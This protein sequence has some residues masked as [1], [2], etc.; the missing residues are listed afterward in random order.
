MDLRI[1]NVVVLGGGT[2]G[3]MSAAYL[4]KHLQALARAG[5]VVSLPG[6]KGGYKLSRPAAQIT[7][8]DGLPKPDQ[9]EGAM[10]SPPWPIKRLMPVFVL[11]AEKCQCIPRRRIISEKVSG[12]ST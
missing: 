10:D 11:N 9:V 8:L 12:E 5:I 3:W 4:A 1:K 7:L 2:A 6:A